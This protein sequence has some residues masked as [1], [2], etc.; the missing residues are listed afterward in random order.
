MRL[1][2]ID[3]VL[4]SNHGHWISH[5]KAVVQGF[6]M[7]GINSVVISN[8]AIQLELQNDLKAIP[9]FKHNPY[10][11][12]N[13][14]SLAGHLVDFS[15]LR[16]STA[17]DLKKISGVNSDD[18]LYFEA[19]SPGSLAGFIDWLSSGDLPTNNVFVSLLEQC[20]LIPNNCMT[21]NSE[22]AATSKMTELW[23]YIGL[24]INKLPQIRFV[25]VEDA[26]AQL[27]GFLL[28]R[29]VH[30]LP[31]PF[32]L[33]K[34]GGARD[35]VQTNKI[36]FI[37]AQRS[38][39]GFAMARPIFEELVERRVNFELY[40][41][42][43]RGEMIDDLNWFEEK[44]QFDRRIRIERFAAD[45]NRWSQ[46]LCS[47]GC[48]VAPYVPEI[49]AVASSGIAAEC[50]S[51][52]VP[53]IAPAHTSLAKVLENYR[54]SDLVA[55]SYTSSSFVDRVCWYLQNQSKVTSDFEGASTRW[56]QENGPV[57]YAQACLSL[58]N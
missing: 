36:S 49:Y 29:S 15:V 8:A 23:R 28:D 19:S 52:G 45:S 27:Y 42:D 13:N 2:Y 24:S 5:C 41:H 44:S 11:S 48:V 10:S 16:A 53:I 56:N 3:P 30:K 31:H 58:I 54:L 6:G 17:D 18:I 20:G 40:I 50:L 51:A 7:L 9:L 22:F 12:F 46:L 4:H 1:I 35:L 14:D 33:V 57:K 34:D 39:K 47:A 21:N 43:S 32:C 37:G 55:R 38:V 26:Y 25:T